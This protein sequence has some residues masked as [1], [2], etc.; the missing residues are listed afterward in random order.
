MSEPRRC[1]RSLAWGYHDPGGI[2]LWWIIQPTKRLHILD[3]LPFEQMDEADLV[4]AVKAKD[5]LLRSLDIERVSYTVGTPAIVSTRQKKPG[6]RGETIGDRLA[7]YGMPIVPAD[8][9]LLNGWKRCQALLKADEQGVPWLTIDP[10]CVTLIHAIPTGLMDDKHPDEVR[11][12][13]PALTALRYGAMS[14]PTPAVTRAILKIPAG[15][16]ADIMRKW[17]DRRGGR[18]FGQAR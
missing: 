6:F 15:S 17:R 16:P 14:R 1:F 10:R 12:P 13:A 2:V 8:D 9:D 5:T 3:E 7:Q 11:T 4:M 18:Q